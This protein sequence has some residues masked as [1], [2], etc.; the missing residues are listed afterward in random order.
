MFD[1]NLCKVLEKSIF[2]RFTQESKEISDHRGGLGI[3]LSIVRE[4]TLSC[5]CIDF[6]SKPISRNDLL[7]KINQQLK[8]K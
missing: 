8:N 2:E 7:R 6:I 5:G 3:G 1:N 4:K